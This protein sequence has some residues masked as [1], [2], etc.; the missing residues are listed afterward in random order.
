MQILY[1]RCCGL[2]VHKASLT[3]CI[4]INESNRKERHVRRFGTMTGDVN[5]L[6]AWLTAHD[7]RKVAIAYASHCTSLG[8]CETFSSSCSLFDNLTPLAF[9]GGLVPGTS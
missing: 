6:A 5:E 3:A 8:R 2:D 1:P 7:V 9:C 4:L